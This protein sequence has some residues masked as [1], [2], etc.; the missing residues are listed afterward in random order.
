MRPSIT[1]EMRHHLK[2]EVD[3]FSHVLSSQGPIGTFIHHNTLHGLQHLPFEEAVAEGQRLLGGRGYLPNEE[4]RRFYR[5][6]RITDDD[7]DAAFSGRP[8]LAGGPRLATVGGQPIEAEQVCRI[9]LLHGIETIDP[10]Q[11]RYAVY[12]GGATRRFRD[13]VPAEARAD[14]LGKAAT[15]LEGSWARVG[16]SWTLA[17]WMRA[18]TNLDLPGWLRAQVA[19]QVAEGETGPNGAPV[20]IWLNRLAIPPDR[21][22]GYLGCIDRHFDGGFDGVGK[23]D[24]A[25]RIWLREE[26]TLLKQLARRHFGIRGTFSAIQR[27]VENDPE[28][29]ALRSLWHACLAGYGLE[30]PFSATDPRHLQERDPDGLPEEQ[31][32]QFRHMERWG[33]PPV[34]LTA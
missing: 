12:E 7:L 4:Y 30:D 26:A 21:R 3:H 15:E 13:D 16:V 23:G 32:E 24:A 27:H 5:A 6:G 28:A 11:L 14:L 1:S 33:G 31:R 34:P 10:A 9:H 2:H 19:R 17:D 8:A 22:D 29:Y 18:Q 25:R 20:E